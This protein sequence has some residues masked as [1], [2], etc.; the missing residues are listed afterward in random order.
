MSLLTAVS[1]RILGLCQENDITVNKLCTMAGVT[2]STIDSILKGKSKNPG[3]CT[4]KKLCDALDITIIDFFNH[5]F[6]KDLDIDI[7]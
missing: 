6:F 7:N 4:I 3:I 1:K 5:S 2:Q